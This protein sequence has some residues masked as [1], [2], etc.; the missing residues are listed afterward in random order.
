M[1]KKLKIQNNPPKIV[2]DNPDK[3]PAQFKTVETTVKIDKAAIKKTIKNKH[4][5]GVHIEQG[6]SLRIK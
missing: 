3:V 2:I 6:T 5:D 4:V 1:E